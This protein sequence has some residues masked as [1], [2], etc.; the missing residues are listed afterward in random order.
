MSFVL[1]GSRLVPKIGETQRRG[2]EAPEEGDVNIPVRVEP[3]AGNPASVRYQWD[4]DTDILS[5]VVDPGERKEGERS[6]ALELEGA[7]GSWLILDVRAGHIRGV[8]VAVWPDVR[9]RADLSPPHDVEDGWVIVGAV[10]RG[11]RL[12]VEVNTRLAAEADRAERTIHFRLGASRETR[13][14]RIARDL[15]VDV[16]RR[17]RIAGLWLLDVPPFPD[18]P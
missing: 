12:A 17:D 9:K 1:A 3:S 15:L 5:A 16:D 8:E 13:T 7:D 10:E 6:T 4:A 18:E 14:V 2:P 11:K